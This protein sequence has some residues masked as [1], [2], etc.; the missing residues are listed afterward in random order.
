MTQCPLA[1]A[2]AVRTAHI[3]GYV[4]WCDCP[5]GGGVKARAEFARSRAPIARQAC[6]EVLFC[7]RRGA[8]ARVGSVWRLLE[9]TGM[10]RRRRGLI[11]ASGSRLA[12]C[13]GCK[14]V[15]G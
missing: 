9:C 8:N 6:G 1:C 3:C 11:L 13:C 7:C 15:R 14:S 10:T 2:P 4:C 5:L 12:A